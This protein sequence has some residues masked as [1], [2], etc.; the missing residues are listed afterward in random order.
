MASKRRLQR[1]EA[2]W[3]EAKDRLD[4]LWHHGHGIDAQWQS[5]V[6]GLEQVLEQTGDDI[7]V[8][9]KASSSSIRRQ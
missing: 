5:D 1:L 4:E 3:T 7:L 6:R 2:E 9:A 8:I